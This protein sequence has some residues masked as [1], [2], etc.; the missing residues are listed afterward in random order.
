MIGRPGGG[1]MRDGK[2]RPRRRPRSKMRRRRS[3]RSKGSQT[4]QCTRHVAASPAGVVLADT[5][6]Q[7]GVGRKQFDHRGQTNGVKER[8]MPFDESLAARVRGVL[9][10]REGVEERR[11]FGCLVF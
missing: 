3:R 10:L 4:S 2:K 5:T 11:M 9:A 7:N 1:P 8:P 6:G